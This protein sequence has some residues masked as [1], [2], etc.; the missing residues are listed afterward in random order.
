MSEDDGSELTAGVKDAQGQVILTIYAQ[1]DSRYCVY[2]THER[3]KIRFAEDPELQ[4]LQRRRLLPISSLRSQISGLMEGAVDLDDGLVANWFVKKLRIRAKASRYRG[5]RWNEEAAFA[6]IDALEGSSD[7]AVQT[8]TRIRDELL[9][10]RHSRGR[11][12]YLRVAGEMLVLIVGVALIASVVAHHHYKP[13]QLGVVVNLWRA[14]TAGALGAFFSIAQS[15]NTRSV[16]ADT[17]HWDYYADAITRISVGC[18]AALVLESL[19]DS[20]LFS[21]KLGGVD[22][23]AVAQNSDGLTK[24][25][26]ILT[27]WPV[28][29]AAGFLAGFSERLIP[30]LMATAAIGA[31]PVRPAEQPA[32]AAEERHNPQPAGDGVK[33]LPDDP[34]GVDVPSSPGANDTLD[35]CDIGPDGTVALTA[36]E[37]LPAASGGVATT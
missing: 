22:M 35:C 17:R 31:A 32:A 5:S 33:P 6:I 21:I 19:L 4:R 34:N 8:L 15:I 26:F 3:I 9:A 10:E 2:A 20:G 36:D 23:V 1:E 37:E 28:T 29:I 24:A 16:R 30:D 18:V 25:G 27:N 11:L 14:V 7:T 12:T 13:P